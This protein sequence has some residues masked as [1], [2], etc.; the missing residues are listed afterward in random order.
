[1][2]IVADTNVLIA[3]IFWSGAPYHIVQLALD[4]K[5]EIITSRQI[6]NEVRKIL[7]DPDE[8]F[9]LKEQETDDVINAILSF[10]KIINAEETISIVRDPKDNHIVGCALTAAAGYIITRDNDLLILKEY[11][12]IKIVPPETFLSSFVH[13]S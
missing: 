2:R 3:S 13:E 1:M 10:A 5:V 6:L 11:A 8:K 12:G 4:E 9:Q 7:T